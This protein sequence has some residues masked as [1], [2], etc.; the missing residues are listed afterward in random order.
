MLHELIAEIHTACVEYEVAIAAC[1]CGLSELGRRLP[2]NPVLLVFSSI[3]LFARGLLMKW[4]G[5]GFGTATGE[6]RERYQRECLLNSLAQKCSAVHLTD[7]LLLACLSLRQVYPASRLGLSLEYV[8]AYTDLAAA[9]RVVGLCRQSAR[10]FRRMRDTAAQ[11]GDPRALAYVEWMDGANGYA[12][13]RDEVGA[14]AILRRVLM[15]H[16]RW[17][18]AGQQI[19]AAYLLC[20][21]L[22]FSGHPV[23]SQHWREHALARMAN[24]QQASGHGFLATGAANLAVLGQSENAARELSRTVEMLNVNQP[25]RK[26]A[27][28]NF[29]MIALMAAVEQ[30]RVGE[31]F[32]S[33][34]AQMKRLRLT[35][36]RAMPLWWQIWIS[37]AQ[38]RVEQFLAATDQ[39]RPARMA[40]ARDAIRQI[41]K[42]RRSRYVLA[43]R[44]IL[45]ATLLQATGA[46][47]DAFRRLERAERTARTL[48]A[49]ILAYDIARVRARA[50]WSMDCVSEAHWQA[51]FALQLAE[52]Y[53]WQHRVRWV[54]SEFGIQTSEH[55]TPTSASGQLN[56][57]RLDALQEVSLAAATVL[58]ARELARVVLDETLRIVGAERAFLFLIDDESSA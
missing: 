50:L 26:D 6:L 40:A 24:S 47:D 28:S 33:R 12:F 13:R 11:V 35:P 7:R 19:D 22:T 34:V 15:E 56:L 54:R 10:V 4:L 1:R 3:S 57:R 48:D 21:L 32:E 18:D 8:R 58:D 38:G 43:H 30:G 29:I 51:G 53:G 23:E 20:I 25:G 31:E 36:R 39:E 17:L 9:L 42:G 44:L 49:P 41:P 46:N 5:L 45:E 52:A 16:S 27:A 2:T 55:R 37:V 14:P